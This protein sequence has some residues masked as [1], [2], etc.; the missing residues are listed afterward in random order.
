MRNKKETR[1]LIVGITGFS[2]RHLCELLKNSSGLKIFGTYLHHP[3]DKKDTV[4]F[5]GIEMMKVDINHSPDVERVIERTSPDL[6]FHFASYVTVAKA[7]VDSLRIFETNVVGTVVLL[8]AVRKISPA[9]KILLPGS[10][11]EYGPVT[12]EKLPIRESYPLRPVNAYGLSKKFEEE[13]GFYYFKTFGLHIY[14]TRTFHYTGPG[15]PDSFVCSSFARQIAGLKGGNQHKIKVGNLKARRDFTDIR[16]VVSAYWKIIRQGKP[17]CV[18][19]V[20]SG[21]LV[22][23]E[24]IIGR[25]IGFSGGKITVEID[26]AKFR[27][28][29]IPEVVGSNRRLRGLG[30]QPKYALS[31]SLYDLLKGWQDAI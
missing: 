26:P 4:C 22:S 23:I 28:L 16:D 31:V 20:C 24:E 27:R 9:S 7:F 12:G 1:V 8:E 30:W 3:P 17:G 15:Q 21:S 18:Y 11:E 25:L 2:G 6:I 13:V 14:F 10:S 5:S 19:N 29:D